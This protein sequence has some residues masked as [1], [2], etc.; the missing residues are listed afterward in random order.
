ML[1]D[2]AQ[3]LGDYLVTVILVVCEA[4]DTVQVMYGLVLVSQESVVR[5]ERKSE[6]VA[7]Y[8]II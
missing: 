7:C 6:K 8:G 4:I 5:K 1:D 2:I 3:L